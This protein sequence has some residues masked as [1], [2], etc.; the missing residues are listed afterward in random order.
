MTSSDLLA[1][2]LLRRKSVTQLIEESS[3]DI[4]SP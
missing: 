3:G 1:Q 4:E 2:Q